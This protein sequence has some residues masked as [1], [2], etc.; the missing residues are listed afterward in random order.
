M[1]PTRCSQV[2]PPQAADVTTPINDTEVHSA[3]DARQYSADVQLVLPGGGRQEL[4]KRS[5][6]NTNS[7][8]DGNGGTYPVVT[9]DWWMLRCVPLVAG[10]GE[11]F[12]AYAP[13]GMRYR[14]DRLV[15]RAHD[16]LVQ[17]A[18]TMQAGVTATLDRS[19][20]LLLPSRIEDASGNWV[21]FDY[22]GAVRD[23]L[24]RSAAA[25][26]ARSR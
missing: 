8:A 14:F 22:G 2:A 23:R 1:H 19:R 18:D 21:E 17:P 25:T 9:G 11:G 7:P 6:A 4:L 13:D 12:L 5:A 24:L 3:F 26:H 10:N 16:A 15:L 20:A